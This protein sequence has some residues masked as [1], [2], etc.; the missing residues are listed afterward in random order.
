MVKAHCY[1]CGATTPVRP[2]HMRDDLSAAGWADS[3]GQTFCQSCAQEHGLPTEPSQPRQRAKEEEP[4]QHRVGVAA[5]AIAFVLWLAG[6]A[7]V[8]IGT[9]RFALTNHCDD[10]CDKPPWDLSSALYNGLPW[11]IAGA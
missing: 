4:P 10:P 1:G 7:V 9:L 2:D 6:I 8:A 5:I 3:A 11:V